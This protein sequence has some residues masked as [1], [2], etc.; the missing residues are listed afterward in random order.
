MDENSF[1]G[2]SDSE[3]DFDTFERPVHRFL[4]PAVTRLKADAASEGFDLEIVSGFRSFERQLD[5]WNGKA[6]GKRLLLDHDEKPLEV[7]TL[8]SKDLIFAILRWSALPGTSRH[9]WGTEIDVI[10]ANALDE[11]TNF[12]LTLLETQEG[13]VFSELHHWLDEY[14]E[15]EHCEFF[16]P[17]DIDRGGVSPE[18]WHLSHIETSKAFQ[19]RQSKR[20][21]SETLQ[22]CDLALKDE[23]LEN[24]DLIYERFVVNCGQ[25]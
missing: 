1:L 22:G 12:Q 25:V 10:D 16:R 13:G 5:I 4:I 9:H 21:L 17:Y 19:C 2:L 23:V 24:L 18:P 7:Q 8:S 20:I 15:H 6:L 11:P 3:I 14:I